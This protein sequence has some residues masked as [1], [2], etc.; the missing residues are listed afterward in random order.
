MK[1]AT[2]YRRVSARPPNRRPPRNRRRLNPRRLLWPLVAL[3][4]LSG[5]AAGAYCALTSPKLRV[6]RVRVVGVRLLDP[7]VIGAAARPAL[8]QNILALSKTRI[9]RRV[10]RRPEVESVRI[11]RIL[12]RTLVVRVQEREPYLTL[13]S[14]GAFWLVDRSGLPFHQ[15]AQAPRSV[16]IVELPPEAD[17]AAGRPV[18]HPGLAAAMRCI[19]DCR[20]WNSRVGKI[21]VDRAGNLCLNIGG[22]FYVKLGQPVGIP[23]KLATVSK[24]LAARPEIGQKLLYIDVSCSERA[25]IKPKP[26][27]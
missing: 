5:V 8:G 11:G 17:V 14:G 13:V 19:E 4:V 12:P 27:A 10:L 22:E 3:V 25:V 18:H 26:G 1:R 15:V 16:P 24:I 9:A 6:E 7:A 2:T 23:E 21:S 20:S